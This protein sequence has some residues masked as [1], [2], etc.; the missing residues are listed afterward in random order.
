MI[1]RGRSEVKFSELNVPLRCPN[2]VFPGLGLETDGTSMVQT[3]D[4][5]DFGLHSPALRIEKMSFAR[6]Q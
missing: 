1:G 2:E 3:V 6:L 4:R 5:C